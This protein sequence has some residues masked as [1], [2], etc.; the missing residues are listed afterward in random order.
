VLKEARG[1][2][3]ELVLNL[4][5]VKILII[6]ENF[7]DQMSLFN[8]NEDLKCEERVEICKKRC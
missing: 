4:S 2:Y 7:D 8:Q 5:E 1:L 6:S 3:E